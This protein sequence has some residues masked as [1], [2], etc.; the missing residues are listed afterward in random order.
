[1]F[2]GRACVQTDS[3][4]HNTYAFSLVEAYVYIYPSIN[5]SIYLSM[6]NILD[7]PNDAS[8]P[9][10]SAWERRQAASAY[11]P[12]VVEALGL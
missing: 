11:N 5:L 12:S 3:C 1:M 2:A 9:L 6:Q 10:M 4:E 8:E 7:R